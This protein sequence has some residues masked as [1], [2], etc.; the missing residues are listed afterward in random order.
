MAKNNKLS[1]DQIAEEILESIEN[2]GVEETLE[3]DSASIQKTNTS[4][5]QSE[6]EKSSVETADGDQ[7]GEEAAA[8]DSDSKLKANVAKKAASAEKRESLTEE[9]EEGDEEDPETTSKDKEAVK[10]D[11]EK[12]MMK[13][14]VE[15]SMTSDEMAQ[16][17]SEHVD[18]LIDSRSDLLTEEQKDET[19]LIFEAA[20]R[21][22]VGAVT[23]IILEQQEAVIEARTQELQE[24]FDNQ[25]TTLV[26]QVDGYLAYAVKEWMTENK[27]AIESSLRSELTE[28]FITGLKDLF[29]ES[30]IDVPEEKY[31]VLAEQ[32]A[33]VTELRSQLDE[34][35]AKNVETSKALMESQRAAEFDRLTTDLTSTEK[36]RLLTMSEGISFDDSFS[37]KVGLLIETNFTDTPSSDVVETAVPLNEEVDPS[38]SK[39][40]EGSLIDQMMKIN[41]KQ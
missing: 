3:E 31:D 17:I 14:K 32:E 10:S 6:A 29:T 21:D 37:N 4:S 39:P 23:G 5:K 34:Q 25:Y 40:K 28:E 27:V 38:A 8:G 1:A 7:G 20:V 22:R 18:K 11:N 12:E 33:T 41:G 36:E 19:A 9:D 15:E 26:E 35:I 13:K 24:S 2:D 16:A 30:Y